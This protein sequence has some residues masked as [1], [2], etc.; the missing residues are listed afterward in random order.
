MVEELIS[1]S[2]AALILGLRYQRARDEMLKGNLGKVEQGSNG[3]YSLRKSEV[4]KRRDQMLDPGR[5]D[6]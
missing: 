1:L 4:E 3:R 5:N 6:V 2:R